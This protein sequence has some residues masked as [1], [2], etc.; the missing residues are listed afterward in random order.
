MTVIK[1]ISY[2][3]SVPEEKEEADRFEH[4]NDMDKW[5]KSI[6]STSVCYSNT[7]HFYQSPVSTGVNDWFNTETLR[8]DTDYE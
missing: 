6:G 1:R 7:E 3:F 2:I 8:K 4:A 5:V